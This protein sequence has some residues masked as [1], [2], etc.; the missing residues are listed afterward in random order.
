VSI[1][2]QAR[3]TE[4]GKVGYLR[5]G[6]VFG[7]ACFKQVVTPPRAS[8]LLLFLNVVSASGYAPAGSWCFHL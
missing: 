1:Q 3:L 2:G 7:S 5:Q 6:L 8:V 4:G